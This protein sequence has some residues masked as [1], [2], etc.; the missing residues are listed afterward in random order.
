M[1]DVLTELACNRIT[2][3]TALEELEEYLESERSNAFESGY[4]RASYDVR[5]GGSCGEGY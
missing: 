3:E 2:V 1:E 4:H 5:C